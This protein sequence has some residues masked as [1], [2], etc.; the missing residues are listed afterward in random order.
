[1]KL[2]REGAVMGVATD[3]D[4]IELRVKAPGRAL[5]HEVFLWPSEGDWG[6]DCGLPSG[7]CVHIAAAAIA[8][9]KSWRDD[10][11]LPQPDV[12]Q[13]VRLRYDFTRAGQALNLSRTVVYPNG[14][15]ELLDGTLANSKLLATRGDAQ[16]EALLA[17][18][19]AGPL[20]AEAMRRIIIF[21][22]GDVKATLD[23]QAIDLSNDPVSFEVRV[24]DEDEGF[25][26]GLYRPA[27]IDEL[28]RGVALVGR[29]VRPTSH[30]DLTPEQRRMLVKGVRFGA[31]EVGRL[32]GDTLPRL[33]DRIP[34]V[35]ATS[36]LPDQGQIEPTVEIALA[37]TVA[38][39]EVKTSLV[40]GDPP[41]AR[42]NKGV[43]QVLG[44][45]V[46]GRD[47]SAE[48][49]AARDF[50]QRMDLSVGFSHI[51]PPESAAVF[52]N[53][54]LP[55][56][57]GPVRGKV[58]PD[59]FRISTTQVNPDIQVESRPSGSWNLDVRF[60][61]DEGEA[62]LVAVMRAWQTGRS[63]VP[64]M[65]GGYAPLPL[66]W[67]KTH[68]PVL[69]ELLD[70]RDNQG[71][72]SR[73]A[74]ATLVELLEA[75]ER[76]TVPPDLKKLRSFLEGGDGLPDVPEPPG[77][78][79]ELRH[80][81]L[82]GYHWLHFLREVELGGILADD[83]GLGKTLQALTAVADCGG[84]SIVVAPTSVLRNWER[85]AHRFFP[86]MTVNVY[87]GAQR[88]LDDSMLTL[89]SYALL[90]L[91]LDKLR[92]RNWDYLILDEAQAIKNPQSQ[93]ARSACA[94]K[95]KHHL[96]LTGTP[97]ENR[98][99]ELW[100]LFRFLMPGFL[101]SRESFRDRYSKPIEAG[102]QAAR[103]AL[104]RRVRPYVLRRLKSQVATELPPLTDMVERCEM[105]ED[106]RRTYEAVR[107]MAREEVQR[108]LTD[109]DGPPNTMHILEA[110]LRMRQACCDP[111][112]LPGE[113]KGAAT[114][115]ERLEELLVDIVA[116][117]HK[118]LVFSQW[119]GLLD[120]VE[121]R[122]KNLGIDWL[123]LDGTTRDRQSVIDHFQ[124]DDGPPV[125]LLSLKAG[126]TGLNLTAA[127]YVIHLDP[128]W[129]PAVQQQATDRAHR[130]GQD[131]P[132][133]SLRLVAADTV[134]ERILDLQDAKR[135]LADA[136]LGTEGGFLKSLTAAELRA[137]FD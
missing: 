93:T 80:Y 79:A 22:E 49:I 96:A 61:S 92:S 120:R 128:W 43:F 77:L 105:G 58:R 118:A 41:V 9:N 111:T 95:G 133:V 54:R 50:E 121:P 112:L 65:D 134:E 5:P 7:A 76:A 29:S 1:V 28:F 102:D 51:L 48:R 44:D 88:E 103:L 63:L 11:S 91:D 3:G 16:T 114:K 113:H 23:G 56:H 62:D 20:S 132:V 101:G 35:I 100:S 124:T 73:Q 126:G 135:D 129:N 136:A 45:V 98:L 130:I 14:R 31:H 70:A 59:R 123:R 122:L 10:E 47:L 131:R 27:G 81:Q 38:G 89:T 107:M 13:R 110:L 71:D 46:P 90:R 127:D 21:L 106:Q 26:V 117:G 86:A 67:L 75:D 97:V 137:L 6:C 87:H 84:Q 109:G 82:V 115:L 17:V 68:G 108:A 30:G 39:L 72:L 60:H 74:T 94:L 125:F 33:R 19:P 34:V 78:Q 66:D 85:E 53:E 52:L 25:K 57:V 36:R 4:E 119:T 15:E 2:A 83:M 99:D 64:L 40:Y 8:Y 24:T 69:R 116:E 18:Q 55:K 37:E 104:R 12:E 32:V 42:V